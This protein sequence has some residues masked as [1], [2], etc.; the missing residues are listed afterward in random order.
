MTESEVRNL[1]IKT[2]LTEYDGD[3]PI[4][5]DNLKFTKPN[6]PEK[7][8]RISVQ[9]ND[10]FQES[11]GI[12][13]NRK[14]SGLGLLF[15]Q[16]FTPINTATD[17]NDSLARASK[18]LFDGEHIQQVRFFNGRIDTIGPDGEFYQQNA[19]VEFE[20]EDIR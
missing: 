3:F 1:I 5:T 16:V 11:L 10:G 18:I 8:V 13:T 15:I 20:F 19:I 14:F 2:Y 7:W 12:K 9:F 6:P 4:A 17:E